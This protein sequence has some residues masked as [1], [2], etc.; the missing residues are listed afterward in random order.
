[1]KQRGFESESRMV[2]LC[3][4]NVEIN[5]S[6]LFDLPLPCLTLTQ[7]QGSKLSSSKREK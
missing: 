2:E 4:S 5:E 1:M 3:R 6:V 7:I